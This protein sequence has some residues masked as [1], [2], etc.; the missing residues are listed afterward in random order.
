MVSV[1]VVVVRAVVMVVADRVVGVVVRASAGAHLVGEAGHRT[2]Y[3]QVSQFIRM[4]PAQRLRVAFPDQVREGS[5]SPIT[6]ATRTSRSGWAAAESADWATIR[7]GST[8]AN[9][10]YG[11]HDDPPRA[12]RGAGAPASPA[13]TEAP[14]RRSRLDARVAAPSQ[15]SRATFA[16]S[17][18]AS[19]SV[20]PRPIKHAPTCRPG[21]PVRR[22]A[23]ASAAS[24]RL[25]GLVQQ[26]VRAER[27][28]VA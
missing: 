9:R 5:Q 12:E 2:R 25:R 26:R 22:A 18:L 6:S 20:E 8:P 1:P 19:G 15:S 17:A 3:P 11:A 7:S 24:M 21:P 27:T 10:K 23:P 14:G 16:T 13:P 4:S 28:T